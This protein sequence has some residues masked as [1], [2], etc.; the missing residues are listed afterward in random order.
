MLQLRG[1]LTAIEYMPLDEQRPT[2]EL[3]IAVLVDLLCELQPGTLAICT[4]LPAKAD[5]SLEMPAGSVLARSQGAAPR[6]EDAGLKSCEI[7]IG[8]FAY[9]FMSPS[10]GV[11]TSAYIAVA[12][13]LRELSPKQLA[14]PEEASLLTVLRA[15]EQYILG[16]DVPPV[17]Q[18][19]LLTTLCHPEV[20]QEVIVNGLSN[21]K[22]QNSA[23]EVLTTCC[24]IFGSAFVAKLIHWQ[25]L[26][27]T[28]SRSLADQ[29]P[30]PFHNVSVLTLCLPSLND[31]F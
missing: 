2:V 10:L 23:I 12:K 8:I 21:P 26:P 5:P 16:G 22:L 19:E 28:A 20:V 31:L 27:L 18:S 24:D 17:N 3:L 15:A 14:S 25:V 1:S 11:S 4:N 30:L 7:C 29:V 9:L 13:K 6:Q